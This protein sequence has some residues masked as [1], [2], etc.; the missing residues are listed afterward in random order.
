MNRAAPSRVLYLREAQLSPQ[1]QRDLEAYYAM[2]RGYFEIPHGQP[3]FPAEPRRIH[4][5]APR[6]PIQPSTGARNRA[7]HPW[8]ADQPRRLS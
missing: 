4:K 1:D 6:R 7:D 8:R 5:S 2:L 3:I